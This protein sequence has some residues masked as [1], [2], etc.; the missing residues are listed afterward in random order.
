[1][2]MQVQDEGTRMKERMRHVGYGMP[3]KMEEAG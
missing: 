1:M 3:I 2:Q